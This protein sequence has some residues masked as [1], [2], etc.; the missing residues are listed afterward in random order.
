MKKPSFSVCRQSIVMSAIVALTLIGAGAAFAQ[1]ITLATSVSSSSLEVGEEFHVFIRLNLDGALSTGGYVDL[2]YNSA[3]LTCVEVVNYDIFGSG[4]KAQ[5]DCPA[6]GTIRITSNA[7]SMSDAT[8]FPAGE[9]F[10]AVTFQAPGAVEAT[11]IHFAATSQMFGTGGG[12]ILT[13]R[14]DS[15]TQ[16]LTVTIPII[17][18]I[19]LPQDD[20]TVSGTYTIDWLIEQAIFTLPLELTL[21][22]SQDSGGTWQPL[23]SAVVDTQGSFEW[24]TTSFVDGESYLLRASILNSGAQ[25]QMTSSTFDIA[26]QTASQLSNPPIPEPSTLLLLGAGIAC[27]V[28]LGRKRALGRK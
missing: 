24:D 5:L 15:A 14:D 16:A 6:S 19:T 20:Q 23:T 4:I 3:D 2:V 22:I 25:F 21:E 28:F 18:S 17:A 11:D 10:A 7:L 13:G 12:D 9:T 27:L 8:T 1:D 26:N